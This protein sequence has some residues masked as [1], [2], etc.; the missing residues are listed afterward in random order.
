ME[1]RTEPKDDGKAGRLEIRIHPTLK[2]ALENYCKRNY[3]SVTEGVTR[4]IK[5][6]IGFEK[7]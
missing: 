2:R 7:K 6:Y 3:E 5:Q 1:K 4:A